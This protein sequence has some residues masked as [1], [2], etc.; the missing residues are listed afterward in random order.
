MKGLYKLIFLI[1][2]IGLCGCAS[3]VKL[4][5]EMF[6]F[7]VKE[8]LDLHAKNFFDP[9]G[10]EKEV[11]IKK[12]DVNVQKLGT[13]TMSIQYDYK[14]YT[15][16]IKI[17][18]KEKPVIHC[19][20]KILVFP[21]STNLK[22]VNKAIQDNVVITD[23][24]DK[25]FEL[26]KVSKIPSSASE[27]ILRIKVK[28]KSGNESDE[29]KVT[30]QFTD[31]G[32]K[33]SN[34]SKQEETAYLTVVKDKHKTENKTSNHDS[35]VSKQENNNSSNNSVQETP[36]KQPSQE[37]QNDSKILEKEEVVYPEEELPIMT[38]DNFPSYLLGNS[39]RVFATYEEANAWAEEQTSIP[40]GPWEDCIMEIIQPFD[41]NYANAGQD[42]TPWTVNFSTMD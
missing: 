36:A 19:K 17:I 29:V 7:P 21:L 1:L 23:N 31:D 24:Y 34:L 32:K 30:L 11:V 8:E 12:S 15:V 40:G 20:E 10:N 9:I 16:R 28:D 5:S 41:G 38:V 33:Q 42:D 2:T 18:D 39:G 4:K 6:E 37:I 26:P 35:S 13:Y 27:V 25:S 14:D 3:D 22:K